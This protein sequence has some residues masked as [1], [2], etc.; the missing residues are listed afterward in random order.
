MFESGLNVLHFFLLKFSLSVYLVAFRYLC[1]EDK[2]CAVSWLSYQLYVAVLC[3]NAVGQCRMV[4]VVE[5]SCQG[6][7][8]SIHVQLQP[9]RST[10]VELVSCC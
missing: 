5:C 6:F 9:C 3:C 7:M 1:K 2:I 8:Q 10:C 4:S